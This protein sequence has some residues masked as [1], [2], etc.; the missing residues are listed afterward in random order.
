MLIPVT[1]V[2]RILCVLKGLLDAC[3][4]QHTHLRQSKRWLRIR[5][6]EIRSMNTLDWHT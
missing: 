5:F 2:L 4:G 3:L 1:A 6:N